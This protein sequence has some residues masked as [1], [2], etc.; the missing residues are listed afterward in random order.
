MNSDVLEV[1]WDYI[2]SHCDLNAI[3][4]SLFLY[5]RWFSMRFARIIN[6]MED[7]YYFEAVL[8]LIVLIENYL[9]SKYPGNKNLDDIIKKHISN[10]RDKTLLHEL[11]KIRNKMAHARL[12]EYYVVFGSNEQFPLNESSNYLY[13]LNKM[14]VFCAAQFDDNY[15]VEKYERI[16]GLELKHY[17]FMEIMNQYGFGDDEA[18]NRIES[19]E[20]I[21]KFESRKVYENA[22]LRYLDNSIATILTEA[23]LRGMIN[24]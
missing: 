22:M 14:F 4:D 13:L 18:I 6:L 8:S 19:S 9:N 3:R 23:V 21:S 7:G 2:N 24:E 17:N 16:Q 15:C 11:R 5:S 1:D 12:I 20:L 10:E